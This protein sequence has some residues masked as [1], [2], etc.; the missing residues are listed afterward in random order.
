VTTTTIHIERGEDESWRELTVEVTGTVTP[1]RAATLLDPEEGGEVEIDSVTCDGK[2]F[3]LTPSELTKASELLE[4][5]ARDDATE[6]RYAR[7]DWEWDERLE[8]RYG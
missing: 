8:K 5:R 4:Q 3:E 2:D 6:A 1:Y 7:A